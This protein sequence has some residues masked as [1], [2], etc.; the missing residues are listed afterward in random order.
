MFDGAFAEFVIQLIGPTLALAIAGAMIAVVRTRTNT[1]RIEVL[2]ADMTK[3][4]TLPTDIAA[5]RAS[6]E[7]RLASDNEAFKRND[8]DH[9]EI[10][11]ALVENRREFKDL[12]QEL[13]DEIR[14]MNGHIPER[15][16]TGSKEPDVAG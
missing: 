14:R 5:L 13:L 15:R 7:A 3:L 4:E 2:E 1:Q 9:N 16:L 12:R 6:V 11:R 8:F 10:K